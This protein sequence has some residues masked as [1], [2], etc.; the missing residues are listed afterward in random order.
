MKIA[1]AIGIAVQSLKQ[2]A[3]AFVKVGKRFVSLK[4]TRADPIGQNGTKAQICSRALCSSLA[5]KLDQRD[6]LF[7]QGPQLFTS[8]KIRKVDHK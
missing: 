6:H 5:L 7:I 1:K 2:F 3:C 8:A 4:E